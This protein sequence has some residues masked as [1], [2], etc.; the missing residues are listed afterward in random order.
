MPPRIPQMLTSEDA[1]KVLA[2]RLDKL[3][4]SVTDRMLPPDYFVNVVLGNVVITRR[5]DGLTST[6]VFA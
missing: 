6:L 5:S 3:E 4:D 2:G 1:V